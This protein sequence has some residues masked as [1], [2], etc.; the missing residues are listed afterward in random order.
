MSA[1]CGDNQNF[2]GQ[3]FNW[4][5]TQTASRGLRN[6]SWQNRNA[7]ATCHQREQRVLFLYF[8]RR[9]QGNAAFPAKLIQ[10][11][12]VV[13]VRIS[14][15][16]DERELSIVL[17]VYRSFDRAHAQRWNQS[18]QFFGRQRHG[19]DLRTKQRYATN[20]HIQSATLDSQQLLRRRKIIEYDL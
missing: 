10:I 9:F 18:Y 5:N 13:A 11:S 4:R 1:E 3:I 15:Q 2:V 7:H 14:I 12:P 16:G 19:P 6:M 17:Q 8:M 20:G